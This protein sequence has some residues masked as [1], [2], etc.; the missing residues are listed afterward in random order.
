MLF[1]LLLAGCAPVVE[2]RAGTTH[3]TIVSLNPCSDAILAE[4]AEPAQLLA[5]SHYSH[6]PRASSMPLVKARRFRATAG[7][8]G[9]KAIFVLPGSEAAVRLAMTRLI[10][11]ELGHVVQ[12]LDK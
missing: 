3:P 11:P 2:R 10:V 4:V 6:D 7:T 12:Q 9:R 5:I 1:V 8:V